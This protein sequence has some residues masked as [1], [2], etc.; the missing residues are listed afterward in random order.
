MGELE[1]AT[2][3]LDRRFRLVYLVFGGHFKLKFIAIYY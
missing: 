1:I 2:D 3:G